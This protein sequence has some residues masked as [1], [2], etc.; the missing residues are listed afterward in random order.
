M[1]RKPQ[2]GNGNFL[3]FSTQQAFDFNIKKVVI[4]IA[5]DATE[6][7]TAGHSP[8]PPRLPLMTAGCSRLGRPELQPCGSLQEEQV[9]HLPPGTS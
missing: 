5:P 7:V 9:Q 3:D 2:Y 8:S 6:S 4:A 1:K